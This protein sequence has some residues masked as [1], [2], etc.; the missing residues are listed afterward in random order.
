VQ[1]LCLDP[2]SLPHGVC[3]TLNFG[4]SRSD[5][6][7]SS[8]SD[9]LETGSLPRKYFLSPVAAAGIIR[10]AKT[11][12]KELPEQLMKALQ[13]V[14]DSAPKPLTDEEIAKAETEEETEE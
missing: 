7:A 6:V 4:E 8:L 12:G 11:R 3:A 10:R 1:V 2:N 5:A 14:V 9:I 13:D